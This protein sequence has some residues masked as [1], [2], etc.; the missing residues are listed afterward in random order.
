[1]PTPVR[2]LTHSVSLSIWRGCF[3]SH[4]ERSHIVRVRGS[5]IGYACIIATALALTGC[6]LPSAVRTPPAPAPAPSTVVDVGPYLDLMRKISSSDPAQQ[7]D[8]FHDV[9]RAFVA[10][11]TTS[12]SLRYAIALTSP[13]HP[14]S[15]PA[16]GKKILETLLASP[17]RMLANE[18][19][20]AA[21]VLQETEARLKLEAESRRLLATVDERTRAQA[22]SERRAQLQVEENAKL[23][24]AL[25]EAEAKLDAIRA[26][27]R[28]IIERNPSPPGAPGTRSESSVETQS[29]PAGR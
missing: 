25:E 20:L 16:E 23:R 6:A 22:N 8:L 9:E 28:T 11:P 1:M 26:I 14:A 18:R 2:I 29:P 21:V 10:A 4:W 27:E 12:S 3:L 5:R 15:N 17:E 13:G 19:L 24:K 7:A